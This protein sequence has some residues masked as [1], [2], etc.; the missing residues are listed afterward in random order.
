MKRS[1]V[2][3]VIPE[4]EELQ[5]IDINKIQAV[6]DEELQKLI[7]PFYYSIS[8]KG[9]TDGYPYFIATRYTERQEWT[10]S[11]E[12]YEK[13]IFHID[14]PDEPLSKWWYDIEADGLLYGKSEYYTAINTFMQRKHAIFH[15]QDKENPISK[16]WYYVR[17][18][19]GI[20][21]DRTLKYYVAVEYPEQKKRAGVFSPQDKYPIKWYRWVKPLAPYTSFPY[22]VV[23]EADK[24]KL[25]NVNDLSV[26]LTTDMHLDIYAVYEKAFAYQPV[27]FTINPDKTYSIY[28]FVGDVPKPLIVH[29]P[30][31][32]ERWYIYFTTEYIIYMKKDT[33][34]WDMYSEMYM[35]DV[36]TQKEERIF[37][38]ER[39]VRQSTTVY[40]YTHTQSK[41]I[42]YQWMQKQ[43]IP[44]VLEAHW[45]VLFDI[46][47]RTYVEYPTDYPQI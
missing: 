42:C 27:F 40:Y 11:A 15:I 4:D 28:M 25:V 36:H 21:L 43:M 32:D 22:L 8:P 7:T 18:D 24:C 19:W 14:R 17:S 3:I 12:L 5:D 38:F 37:T 20:T 39:P 31:E 29:Q 44:L 16:W 35:I 41:D 9:I 33:R 6:Y 26:P 46:Q 30:I 2:S 10:W 34:H 47:H 45:L 1:I 13:A 23:F